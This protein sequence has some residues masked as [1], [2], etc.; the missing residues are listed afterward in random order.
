MESHKFGKAK[1]HAATYGKDPQQG[2]CRTTNTS[3]KKPLKLGAAGRDLTQ[4]K[5]VFGSVI[6]PR[7]SATSSSVG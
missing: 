2:D 4:C 3:P 1:D 5:V 6:W 7:N